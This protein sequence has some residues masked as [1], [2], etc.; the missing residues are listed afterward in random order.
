MDAQTHVPLLPDDRLAGVQTHPHAHLAAVGPFVRREPP[1][2]R[3]RCSERRIR[4]REGEEE[5]IALRVH[6]APLARLDGLPQDPLLRSE[7]LAVAIAELPEQPRRAFDVREQE[8]DGSARELSH[9]VRATRSG[10]R[11]Q[12]AAASG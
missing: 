6:L 11:C 1:L 3:D 2:G 10:K 8:G 5:G 7:N 9:L 12:A 4:P